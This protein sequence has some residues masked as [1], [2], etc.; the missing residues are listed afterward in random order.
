MGLDELEVI[1]MWNE[2]NEACVSKMWRRTVRWRS[3][4]NKGLLQQASWNVV[5]ALTGENQSIRIFALEAKVALRGLNL[6][7]GRQTGNW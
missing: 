6:A 4:N 5:R 1:N 3:I 7:S 2:T